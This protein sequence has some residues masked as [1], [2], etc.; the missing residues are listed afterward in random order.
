MTWR[1]LSISRFSSK[2]SSS[3]P[4][5]LINVSATWVSLCI[6]QRPKHSTHLRYGRKVWI[7]G[8]LANYAIFSWIWNCIWIFFS[9]VCCMHG[10]WVGSTEW[11]KAESSPIQGATNFPG[12]PLPP[13]CWW[14]S[15]FAMHFCNN[16]A[17]LKLPDEFRSS[18][19]SLKLYQ[20]HAL[21]KSGLFETYTLNYS[22]LKIDMN[23]RRFCQPFRRKRFEQSMTKF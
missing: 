5:G 18:A 8:F 19:I 15:W 22:M 10:G 16:K 21:L 13:N 4:K 7:Q 20:S 17:S 1:C 6:L 23:L 11:Q 9:F 2:S 3:S 14:L 12:S